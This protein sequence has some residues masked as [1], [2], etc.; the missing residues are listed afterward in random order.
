[1]FINMEKSKNEFLLRQTA[2]ETMDILMDTDYLTKFITIYTYDDEDMVKTEFT[3][4]EEIYQQ[5]QQ[6]MELQGKT[7][8]DSE[9]A[10]KRKIGT[11]IKKVYNIT[12]KVNDSDMYYKRNNNI[13]SYRIRLKSFD[14][15][16][17]EFKQVY[18]INE[19]AGEDKL[20]LIS[21]SNDNQ[22]VYDKIQKGVN[23][24]NLLNKALPQND[25]VKIVKELVS[26]NLITR[27]DETNLNEDGK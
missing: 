5:Y 12:G 16:N 7:I 3:T 25:N 18:T 14:E 8:V 26:L 24:I 6:Y 19:D 17:T 1:M 22:I 9:I 4:V 23:T 2:E 27:Q 15:V 21:Y 20:I 11:T 10:V 13:A